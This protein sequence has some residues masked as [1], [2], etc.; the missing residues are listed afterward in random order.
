MKYLFSDNHK[1]SGFQFFSWQRLLLL[2]LLALVGKYDMPTFNHVEDLPTIL[3]TMDGSLFSQ[4]FYVLEQTQGTPRFI[5]QQ[6]MAWLAQVLGSVNAAYYVV[7][8]ALCYVIL[9]SLMGISHKLFK[10]QA[11]GWL[12]FL[13]LFL[14]HWQTG[15]VGLIVWI[16][17]SVLANLFGS[18]AVLAFAYLLLTERR[19]WAWLVLGLALPYQII[20]GFYA[21]LLW[22]GAWLWSA[23]LKKES[24]VSFIKTEVIPSLGILPG[25]VVAVLPMVLVPAAA[26]T[27]TGQEFLDIFVR[28]RTPHHNLP[29]A[30]LTAAEMPYTIA[31]MV[32]LVLLLRSEV[33]GAVPYQKLVLGLAAVVTALVAV[34]YVGIEVLSISAVAKLQLSRSSMLFQLPAFM[35]LAYIVW[36]SWQGRMYLFSLA[37]LFCF[38]VPFT[39]AFVLVLGLASWLASK[40]KG[41]LNI[42]AIL[43][44]LGVLLAALWENGAWSPKALAIYVVL[45][46][47][48]FIVLMVVMY[49]L[50]QRV[51]LKVWLS[52]ALSVLLLA[53]PIMNYGAGLLPKAIGFNWKLRIDY[54]YEDM[55]LYEAAQAQALADTLRAMTG[56]E[57]MV[58]FPID[59]LGSYMRLASQRNSWVD[60]KCIPYTNHGIAEWHKRMT[61]L[62]GKEVTALVPDSMNTQYGKHLL[63]EVGASHI[64][65]LVR[66]QK[67]EY[68]VFYSKDYQ[69]CAERA[70]L[71]TLLYK[72]EDYVLLKPQN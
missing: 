65:E 22:G 6:T 66:Q 5:Y 8:Y 63:R 28:F 49:M 45:R 71:G 18:A 37:L 25:L 48:P 56:P 16:N 62:V 67:L 3:H 55:E 19:Y 14:E 54:T 42:G 52:L 9:S 10:V 31:F 29:S 41:I 15:G 53:V 36:H 57:T 64:N 24:M 27:L 34:S 12:T 38:M 44:L 26:S 47:V 35:L 11:I 33:V 13:M 39:G 72:N 59:F 30:Y 61:A 43:V 68:L 69:Q 51:Q 58:L 7:W 17:H 70:T 23:W 1:A 50:V 21:A 46:L 40:A 32:G 2:C 4:D 60:F 20:F